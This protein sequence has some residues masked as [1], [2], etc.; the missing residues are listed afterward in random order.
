MGSVPPPEKD[1]RH[2]LAEILLDSKE[3]YLLWEVGQKLYMQ[4]FILPTSHL[5]NAFLKA[6][7][8]SIS[9]RLKKELYE[10]VKGELEELQERGALLRV[11]CEWDFNDLE[12]KWWW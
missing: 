2:I 10:I 5:S 1:F 4:D 6:F 11:K 7:Y 3:P 8:L 12:D 9:C